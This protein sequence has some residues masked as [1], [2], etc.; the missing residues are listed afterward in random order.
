M[1]EDQ[2]SKNSVSSSKTDK[3]TKDWKIVESEELQ[4]FQAIVW[5]ELFFNK[6]KKINS[7]V[8]LFFN[9]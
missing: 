6:E 8:Q 1:K 9:G 7:Q 3:M 2:E 5:K 4:N